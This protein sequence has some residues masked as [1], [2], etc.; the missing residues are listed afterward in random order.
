VC[1]IH[2]FIITPL[3]DINGVMGICHNFSVSGLRTE[4]DLDLLGHE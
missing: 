2:S 4:L 3:F 1:S